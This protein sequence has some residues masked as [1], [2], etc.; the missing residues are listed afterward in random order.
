M[1]PF[2]A[3]RPDL[4]A[5]NNP[6][7]LTA[8][9]VLPARGS[10]RPMPDLAVYSGALSARAQGAMFELDNAGNVNGFAGDASKLYRL[11]AASTAWSDESIAGGY[12]T[13]ADERWNFAQDGLRTLATNF[14]DAIQSYV[15]GTSTEFAVLSANAPK[16]RYMKMAKR[17]LVT[18]NTSDGTDGNV[19]DRVWWS[20]IDDVT[21]WPT[22]GGASAVAA[23][24]GRLNLRGGGGWIM[25]MAAGLAGADLAIWQERALWR[26]IYLGG[27]LVWQFDHVEGARGTPAPGS[28]VQLGGVIWYLGEDGFYQFD[29]MT[30]TPIGASKIDKT[31]YDELDQLYFGRITSA[32]DPV[33]KLVFWSYPNSGATAGAPN[34]FVVYNWETGE[35]ANGD[36][37]VQMLA[38]T[39]S[40]GYT[41]ETLDNINA[42]IDALPFSLDSRAYTDGRLLLSAFDSNNKLD[43][44][45]GAN[46]AATIDTGEFGDP[47][48][49]RVFVTG[50]RPIVD[51]G[52]VTAGLRYRDTPQASLTANTATAAGSDGVC[53]QRVSTRYA[54]GRVNIA[55]G[56]TWSHAQ[57]IEPVL[58]REGKR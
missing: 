37:V 11:L 7:A 33:N 24:S 12:T 41:V 23:Q 21:D 2:G 18:A 50:L 44:F 43:Y 32:V 38:T 35:W 31:F 14:T 45:T 54:R 52:T 39:L 51:G 47:G 53:P 49:R 9:N 22:P 30:S 20:A 17:F 36:L 48:G 16:C 3:Y 57:G 56:G 1:I 28:I 40:F 46:L 13:G 58:R 29:G 42:S 26:A 4:P 5:Y 25:G 27:D 8:K 34:R 15:I 55:A 19:P 10:Y 6:G